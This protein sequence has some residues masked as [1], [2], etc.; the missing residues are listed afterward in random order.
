MCLSFYML[1]LS[2]V[3]GWGKIIFTLCGAASI[4]MWD[5]KQIFWRGVRRELCLGEQVLAIFCG[6]SEKYLVWLKELKWLTLETWWNSLAPGLQSR[7]RPIE[8][9]K[10]HGREER[11]RERQSKLDEYVLRHGRMR[12]DWEPQQ[13]SHRFLFNYKYITLMYEKK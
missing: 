4:T 7:Y 12:R 5:L 6:A 2:F 10:A 3:S 1:L 8:L 11:E 13:R 9:I